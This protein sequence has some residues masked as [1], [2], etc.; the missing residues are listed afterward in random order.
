M[1]SGGCT[2]NGTNTPVAGYNCEGNAQLWKSED[3]VQ[4]EYVKPITPGG[5]GGYWEL[6]YLL[7]FDENGDAIDNYHHA[8]AA[9]YALLF[10]S[11]NAYYVGNYDSKA[12]LFA[13]LGVKDA[14]ATYAAAAAD[15]DAQSNDG[16]AAVGAWSLAAGSGS[17]AVGPSAVLE[18]T[19]AAGDAG[20]YFGKDSTL[21]I[22]F[23]NGLYSNGAG[24]SFSFMVQLNSPPPSGRG[25]IFEKSPDASLGLEWWGGGLINFYVRD[26]PGTS[27][28]AIQSDISG[29]ANTD[30]YIRVAVSYDPAAPFDSNIAMFADGKKLPQATS[31]GGAKSKCM[32]GTHFGAIANSTSGV[33]SYGWLEHGVD[34]ADFKLYAGA[35][36]DAEMSSISGAKVPT[37][38]PKPRPLPP[39]PPSPPHR[40]GGDPPA[41]WPNKNMSDSPEYYSFNPHGT[42][43]RGPNNSTRRLMFG[44]LMTRVTSA[45]TAKRLPYWQS[46]HSMMRTVTVR[47]ASLVQLPA[48]GTF[49]PLRS[50]HQ[51][52]GAITVSANGS[53]YLPN[54][55]GDAL[56]IVATFSTAVADTTA[57]SFGVSLRIGVGGNS[58]K[59]CQIGYS[60]SSKTITPEGWRADIAPQ[61]TS[62]T[63]E[64]HIFLDRS[65]VETY[66]GGA[67]LSS[68]CGLADWKDGAAAKGV[69]L[70]AV[71]GSAKLLKFEAW[72]MGSMWG[73]VVQ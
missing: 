1:L 34:L 49:E 52:I 9:V 58:N 47:G 23:F 42:D 44:W 63:V 40:H 60:P 65:I 14:V 51:S 71:G 24:F 64:L 56:E 18:H 17:S 70:W 10:G 37:P 59:G 38:A 19:E 50:A 27:F 46:A 3:L 54:V 30:Q 53:K 69:D 21:S 66:T 33:K 22:P 41:G 67:A 57:T 32:P 7:A 6:P 15:A 62:E 31:C 68:Y 45:V 28:R 13:P 11:G 43:T 20:T 25:Y 61:P 73:K 48:A 2:Y 36:T 8:D 55:T 72:T 29:V 12:M 35:L 16:P 4:F 39:L 26:A 5:D